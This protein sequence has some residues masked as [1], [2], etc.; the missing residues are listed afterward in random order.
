LSVEKRNYELFQEDTEMQLRLQKLIL[1]QWTAKAGTLIYRI[2]VSIGGRLY[3][4]NIESWQSGGRAVGS[5][6]DAYLEGAWQD[7]GVSRRGGT[8]FN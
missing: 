3:P 8:L 6:F 2:E 4:I 1:F 7:H 5:R